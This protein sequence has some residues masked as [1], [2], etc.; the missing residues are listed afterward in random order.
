MPRGSWPGIAALALATLFALSTGVSRAADVDVAQV[1]RGIRTLVGGASSLGAQRARERSLAAATERSYEPGGY[2]PLWFTSA[3]AGPV[4]ASAIA[5][6]AAA[7]SRGLDARDYATEWLADETRAIAEG[8]TG[9]DRIARVDVAITKALLGYLTDL[10]DGRVAPVASGFRIDARDVRFDAAELLRDALATGRVRAAIAAAEP[11]LPAYERLKGALARYRDLAG[12]SWPPL[13]EPPPGTT[14]I[15]PGASYAGAYALRERLVL[16]GDLSADP[17]PAPSPRYDA[18]LV[19]AVKRFQARHGLAEDG[20]VGRETR[21]ELDVP[22]ARRAR[23]IELALERLRWLP[24]LPP[25]PVIA[26]NVP[27]YRLWAFDAPW[28]PGASPL[29]MRVIVGRAS[30]AMQTPIFA[31]AMRAIEF[32]PYWNVPQSIVR[33]EILPQ[34]RHDAEHLA[35]EEM[36]IVGDGA[37]VSPPAPLDATTLARLASGEL[38][39]RQRPGPKNALGGIKFVLPNAMSIYLHGT[40]AQELFR[41]TR[42]DFSHGCIRVEDPLALA[43]FALR[44]RPEWTPERMRE[45][46]TT[47]EPLTVPLPWPIAVLIFYTTAIVDGAGRALFLPDVY[48]Y[49]ARLERAL[50]ARAATSGPM[51]SMPAVK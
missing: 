19:V 36:E 29:A 35:R 3:G 26:I 11:S 30:A 20:I 39:I 6:L 42:R 24:P 45:A 13:P 4:V 21:R 40:P 10:H 2:A 33:N 38:R 44:D 28:A 8:R 1:Q 25:G 18:T 7:P 49:D 50:R 31:S 32:S 17:R 16:L 23:Q 47:R 34:L 43:G 51:A 27:S 41:S 48:G 12:G 37:A 15:V 14:K 9:A 46:M 5:E 22:P